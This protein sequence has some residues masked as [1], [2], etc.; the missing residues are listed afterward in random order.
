MTDETFD[1][2]AAQSRFDQV[3][4][5]GLPPHANQGGYLHLRPEDR[6]SLGCHFKKLVLF[7]LVYDR[8]RVPAGCAHC[9]KV[10][11]APHDLKGVVAVRDILEELGYTAKSGIDLFNPHSGDVWAA[12]IY[13]DGLDEARAVHATL[14]ARCDAHADLG[15]GLK[16]TIKRGCSEYEAACGPSDQWHFAPGMAEFEAAARTRYD[17]PARN[18]LPYRVRKSLCMMEWIKLAYQMGDDT[19]LAFTGGKPLHAPTKTYAPES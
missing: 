17:E 5:T 19:Y 10:K 18:E 1:R 6:P 2:A 12:F 3:L 15:P 9:F 8:K 11:A 13:T 16:I 7:D 4:A 14:R